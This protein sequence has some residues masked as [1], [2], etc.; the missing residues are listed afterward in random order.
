MIATDIDRSW[1][2]LCERFGPRPTPD[3]FEYIKDDIFAPRLSVEP[4]GIVF[5]GACGAVSDGCIDSEMGS[6]SPFL[7]CRTC[8]HDNIG[9][10]TRIVKR[11]SFINR[12]LRF[13]NWRVERKR[14]KAKYD[15]IYFSDL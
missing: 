15:V 13:E 11:P 6:R 8:C 10:N 2:W 1:N 12:F 5:F 3:N 4:A 7:R 14:N 9:G